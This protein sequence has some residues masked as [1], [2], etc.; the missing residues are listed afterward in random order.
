MKKRSFVLGFTAIIAALFLSLSAGIGN[1]AEKTYSFNISVDASDDEIISQFAKKLKQELESRS[2]GQI[3]AKV[4]TN[5]TLGGDAEALQS[6]ADGSIAFVL[7]T[8]G[9]QVNMMHELA[10]FDLPNLYTNIGEFRALFD[11]N[12]FLT[13]L[14]SIYT[15]NGF[16]L[17]GIADSG[18][19]VMTSNKK[20]ATL[21]DLKGIKIRTMQNANHIAIWKSYGANPTPMAFGEVYIGL[22]Q[23]TID[24]QEN[25]I[26]VA[27]A[28]KFYEQQKYMI[29]TNHLPHAIVCLMSGM[30]YND[31]PKNLQAVVDDAGKAATRYTRE[32]SDRQNKEQTEFVKKHGT[33]VIELPVSVHQDMHK[34]ASPVYDSIKKQIGEEQMNLLLKTV[35]K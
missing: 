10:M 14:N 4:Y 18:F 32:L 12:T 17:L 35:G 8:T 29:L 16:H 20:V 25:P 13:K 19:R 24:A 1:T 5:G 7:S 15:K 23:G 22:Q 31:L 30:L 2:K 21:A 33:Q 26:E 11:N 3:S 27:V 34:A 6:C 9:P 28:G